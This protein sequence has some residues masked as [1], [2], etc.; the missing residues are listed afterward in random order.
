[1]SL[2]QTFKILSFKTWSLLQAAR[3]ANH[4]INEETITDLL[5]VYLKFNNSYE[6]FTRTFTRTEEKQNGSDWEWWLIDSTG[7]KG[8]GFRVQAKIINFKS[9]SFQQL[10]YKNQNNVLI[11]Q[12]E[13]SSKKLIPIYCLYSHHD[14]HLKSEY[15]CSIMS[16]YTVKNLK[17]AKTRL[18]KIKDIR[19]HMFPWH[20]LVCICN[21]NSIKTS[22]PLRAWKLSQQYG[23]VEN[24][25]NETNG[26]LP[27]N[28]DLPDYVLRLIN[29]QYEDNESVKEIEFDG[30]RGIMIIKDN[31]EFD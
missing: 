7:K 12:A 22:L 19:P 17:K 8:L 11:Y 15:G 23:L 24:L 3:F 26:E 13:N 27:N 21:L 1:M 30:L 4:Q 18:S 14:T 20:F 25:D 28:G 9:D 5:M 2:C 6:I 29:N 31:E 10:Y 16:A